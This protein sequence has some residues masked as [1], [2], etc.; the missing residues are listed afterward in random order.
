MEELKE[1]T[2]LVVT[3]G[4][5]TKYLK[6]F[7]EKTLFSPKIF[8]ISEFLQKYYFS[9]DEKA[10]YYLTK[11]YHFKYEVSTM[12]LSLLYDIKDNEEFQEEKIKKIQALKQELKEKNLLTFHPF[13]HAYL[14]GKEI[15]FDQV[16]FDKRATKLYQDLQKNFSVRIS[17]QKKQH[18]LPDQVYSFSDIS[19]EVVYVASTILEKLK[20]GISPK[21][22]KLCGIEGEYVPQVKRI[23][24]WF[25]LPLNLSDNNLYGTKIAQDF[26]RNFTQNLR[27]NM[28]ILKQQYP[29]LTPEESEIIDKITEIVNHYAWVEDDLL[30][31]DFLIHDFKNTKLK[32]KVNP[33]GIEVISHLKNIPDDEYV[34][35][36]GF[37]QGIIP[38][39]KKDEEYFNDTL[40][41]KLG[42]LTTKEENK[43]EKE[44]WI[45]EI[46]NVKNL[47]ITEKKQSPQGE[48]YLSS[49]NDILNMKV[50][51]GKI[52]YQYS[53]LYNELVL[54]EKLDTLVKYNEKEED[55]DY[56]YQA[57]PNIPYLSYDST[58]K[59]IDKEKLKDY[60]NGHLTLSYSAMNSYYQCGFRYYLSNILKL[61][62][63]PNTFST[64]LG[65]IFHEV[66]S[67]YPKED[68]DF[69]TIYD[70]TIKKYQEIYPFNPKEKFFL[71]SLK[72]ELKFI[73]DTIF[74]QEKFSHLNHIFV[75]EKITKNYS[76]P[77]YEVCFKGFVDKMA[78]NEENTLVA[79]ID[80]KTGN[81]NLNLNHTIYGLDLQLPTYLFLAKTKF[82]Q[83][84]IVGFY[85]QKILN[86]EITKDNKHTYL[87]L[88]QENLKLQGYSN[89][90]LSILSEFDSTYCQSKVIKGMRTTQTGLGTKKVLDD[91]KIDAL[92]NLAEDKIKEAIQG[93][94]N[95]QFSI[96]PKRIKDDNLG[97]KYCDYRDICYRKEKDIIDLKECKNL[98]FLEEEPQNKGV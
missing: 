62:L 49:L 1:N 98:A 9:Y 92:S 61:N 91:V 15:V 13:F 12:Y 74:Q 48:F 69:S 54:G 42:L 29:S 8:T 30:I 39:M 77:G 24:S 96:N 67:K 72:K 7:Q 34:F 36:L 55:L 18:Y 16:S 43:Q 53:K 85:L 66:L 70:Q 59:G 68:F 87:E 2:I 71:T 60:L 23:F 33:N 84:R 82:P 10:I 51:P 57:Y 37:N 97:C 95:A 25:A 6:S 45:Q 52:T 93:I 11:Q 5:K 21:K 86:N 56:L 3:D 94:I 89:S 38:K 4:E 27:E 40:K 76:Y 64:I 28:T 58:F 90:D 44:R 81:P 47:I 17:P 19:K 35:L 80:Y 14:K 65:N 78:L 22:I 83:A 50:L 75:E 20:E 32:G 88:K 46:Q 31:K 41:E 73:L 26:L 63:S 79:I